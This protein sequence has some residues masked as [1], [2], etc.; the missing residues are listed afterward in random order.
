[1]TT[2]CSM[3]DMFHLQGIQ[4]LPRR[5]RIRTMLLATI[6][7]ALAC[8]M[9]LAASPVAIGLAAAQPAG[10]QL[11][12]QVHTGNLG[13]EHS[14]APTIGMGSHSTLLDAL[15]TNSL[16]RNFRLSPRIYNSGAI[17]AYGNA[18]LYGSLRNVTLNSPVVAMAVTPDGGGY[19]L[20]A[21]DGG[22]FAFGDAKY[23]GSMGGKPLNQPIVGIASTPDGKG[24]WLV[25][26][27]GGI[28]AFGDARFLGSGVTRSLGAPVT[29]VASTP[30]GNGY[31]LVESDGGVS[32]FGD[33]HYWGSAASD[34]L[35]TPVVAIAATSNGGGYWLATA[36]GSVITFGNAKY[37]GSDGAAVPAPPV[38]AIAAA[39]AGGY[40]LLEP[41]SINYSFADPSPTSF[42]GSSRIVQAAASQVT[43]DPDT[44][45]GPFC[46]PYGPCEEWCALFA[47]WVWR[48]AGIPIPSYAFTGDVYYWAASYG[49]VL[50]PTAQPAPG[51]AVLYGTGPATVSTSVH[52]GIVAQVWPDGAVITIEA[53]AGPSPVGYLSVIING[54]YLPWDSTVY[55]GF[56]VYAFAQPVQ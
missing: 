23:Y 33:A 35:T 52:M 21:A 24:Y 4:T 29:G 15:S 49:A 36:N 10:G 34:S 5:K 11:A 19:W 2:T 38:A 37:Y 16:S 53:D 18:P 22:V 7:S 14:P 9:V 30:S 6:L 55:N 27:D 41:D 42:P 43:A 3:T 44:G 51:D 56:P 47:T 28:F 46:N 12:W 26:A 40:Y 13:A 25:A 8:T 54:P 50:S 48:D 17:L 31:W 32:A 1:M 20:T 45:Q 39:P